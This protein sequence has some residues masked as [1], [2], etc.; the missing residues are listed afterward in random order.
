MFESVYIG[1]SGLMGFSK[2]LSVLSNNVANLNTPGYKSSQL[3]FLD[4][5]YEF[6]HNGGESLGQFGSGIGTGSTSINMRQ[7]ELRET[8]NDLDLAING[9]GFFVLRKDDQV[10]YTRAGQFEFDSDGFLVSRGTKTRVAALSSG[11]QLH[12]INLNGLRTNPPKATS[13]V[14]FT[15]N[16]SSSGTQHIINNINIFDSTGA[17]RSLTITFDNNSSITPGNWKLTIADA[18]GTIAT[19]EI[20]FDNG[21]LVS[22]SDKVTFDYT[23]MGATSSTIT[24][25]F[26]KDVTN[27][28]GGNDSSLKMNTKDGFAPGALTKTSFDSEGYLNLSYSNGQTTKHDR[29]ALAWFDYIN[30]LTLEGN[31]MFQNKSGLTPQYGNPNSSVFGPIKA[32]SIELSNVDLTQQFSDLIITQRG[33]QASSQ[34]ITAANEMMQQ[35]FDM[36]GRR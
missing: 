22:G 23:P 2:G 34:V 33:Y 18:S 31:N 4:L 5:M 30:G 29:L 13:K 3:Q 15:G 17:S 1:M 11:A 25:D 26:S 28:S 20:V 10:H 6:K 12:D 9:S 32:G 8:G 16:L 19:G 21:Q 27:F 7:G 36:K 35:L 14:T 24:L